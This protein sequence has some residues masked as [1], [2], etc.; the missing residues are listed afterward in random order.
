LRVA[1]KM[2]PDSGIFEGISWSV[3]RL[4]CLLEVGACLVEGP[5]G[6]GGALTRF[7]SRIEAAAPLPSLG[8]VRIADAL[9]DRTGMDVA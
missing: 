9:G 5:R 4:P 3:S 2:T 8:V 1:L 7:R 6:A